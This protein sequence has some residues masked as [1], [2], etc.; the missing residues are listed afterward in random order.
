[1]DNLQRYQRYPDWNEKK[2]NNVTDKMQQEV[3]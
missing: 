3:I 1:M 2:D